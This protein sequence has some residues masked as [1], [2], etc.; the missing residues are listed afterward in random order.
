LGSRLDGKPAGTGAE[1]SCYS[2]NGNKIITTS[3]GGALASNDRAIVEQ[4]RY[5]ATQAREPVPYYQHKT[6]GYNYRL[7]NVLAAIGLGQLEVL[8]DRVERRRAIFEAYC[9]RLTPF[10]I[11]FMPEPKNVRGNRWLTVALIDSETFGATRDEVIA[12]LEAEDI[13]SRPVW[14][15]LHMQPV[16]EGAMTFGGGTAEQLFSKGICLPSGT[17][18]TDSDIERICDVIVRARGPHNRD[19]R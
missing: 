11:S 9:S 6:V 5:L 13:E 19:L 2:F 16:F 14:K 10:G 1:I 7:S 3:G 17:S 12:A 4:A 8:A 18:L 15:P